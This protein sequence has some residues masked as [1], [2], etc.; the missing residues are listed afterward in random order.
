MGMGV[1]GMWCG[2][3]AESSAIVNNHCTYFIEQLFNSLLHKSFDIGGKYSMASKS[4]SLK[5]EI[6]NEKFVREIDEKLIAEDVKLHA[7]PFHVVIEWMKNKKIE[8]DI[9]DETL[10]GP[11]MAI[12]RRLYPT[13]D[14]S[15]PSL[16]TGGV[17][18]RDIMYPVKIP[19][20]YGTF[21]VD[22][23]KY[24]DIKQQEL[25]LIFRCYPEQGWR[26]FYGVCDLWDFGYG[27][28]DLINTDSPARDLLN[29]AR[30]SVAA[31][32]R[33]LSGA[34][35]LDSA[36][37]TA[38]LTAELSMKAVLVH[39]GWSEQK[40]RKLSHSLVKLADAI[41]NEKPTKNDER[42]REACNKF[43]NYV[44][45]RYSSHGL[46]RLGL[47]NLAMRAQFVAADVIRRI[48]DRNI[49]DELEARS[50]CP[51]RTVP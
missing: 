27:V 3:M 6:I 21:S 4:D 34:I 14:F 11:L 16:L 35:D 10:W 19:V 28:D 7:R 23:L 20:G 1:G 26:A 15:M 31:T 18:L 43:P 32:P 48:S 5:M 17:A 42:L 45:S 38:C 50:D 8:G 22:P 33:I 2:F 40:I 36:V 13:G 24:I 49:G 25:E 39:L 9:L 29:N 44:M 51:Q 46:T 12:Y 37:Q 47:M 41:I 30:S